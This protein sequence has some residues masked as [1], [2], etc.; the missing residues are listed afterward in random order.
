MLVR[1]DVDVARGGP[2][3]RRGHDPHVEAGLDFGEQHLMVLNPGEAGGVGQEPHWLAAEHRHSPRIPLPRRHVRIS[4]S[5]AV[6]GKYWSEVS[7]WRRRQLYRLAIWEQ[8]DKDV[9]GSQ[10]RVGAAFEGNHPP[11]GRQTG[12][13]D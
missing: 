11:V 6:R 3:V 8:L 5:C 13:A 7:A 2:A 9:T 12:S 1:I 4:D 10:E